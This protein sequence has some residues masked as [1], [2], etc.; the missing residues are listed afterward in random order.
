MGTGLVVL[1]APAGLSSGLSG[2]GLDPSLPEVHGGGGLGP[3]ALWALGQH[4]RCLG[5]ASVCSS[6]PAKLRYHYKHLLPGHLPTLEPG[7][8]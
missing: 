8:S 1:C 6:A 2:P 7:A 5:A 4:S 3:A